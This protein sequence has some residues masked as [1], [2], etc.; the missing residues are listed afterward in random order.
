[1]PPANNSPALIS[2]LVEIGRAAEAAGHGRKEPIYAAAAA[3]LGLSRAT[4]LRK[5]KEVTVKPERKQRSDAG[6]TALP[7]EEAALIS[8]YILDHLRKNEKRMV[9]LAKAVEDLRRNGEIRAEFVDAEGVIRPLSCTA[10]A[11]ALRGHQMHPDQLLRP[12]P[13]KELRSLHPNHVWEIDASL[14]VLFY[15]RTS[16]TRE[17][18]LRVMPHAEFYKNKPANLARIENDR[19]WRYVATD[20]FSGAVQV[21]Y[22]LGAESGMN[23]TDSLIKFMQPKV[24]GRDPVHGAPLILLMDPG[25]ANT[26]GPVKNFARRMQIR[27]IAH[28]AGNARAT[29]QVE[30][31]QDLVECGFESG[32][33]LHPVQ[34]L[35]ELNAVASIWQR[36][37]N[38]TRLHTRTGQTRNAVWLTIKEAELRIPP[39]ADLCRELFTHEPE[40]RKVQDQLRVA[41]GGGGR[42]WDVSGVPRVMVGES[43][44]VTWNPY[45]PDEQV[46]I[47][48][49][50]E[51]GN[52]LLH[53]APLV[54]VLDD[55]GRF[56][57]DANV[58]GEEWTRHA[59]TVAD[60]HRKELELLATE[61][62]T[63][64]E[65][66]KFRKQRGALAFGGR[67]DPFKGLDEATAATHYL[68]RKG[69]ELETA[70]QLGKPIERLLTRFEAAKELAARGVA[71]SPERNALIAQWHPDGVPE[72]ALDDLQR[73][74]TVRNGLR[75]VGSD[76]NVG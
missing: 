21:N 19:V 43:L 60:K 67:I 6:K 18:G 25:S 36:H 54:R 61:T 28:K 10:I 70:T 66:A 35:D 40:T 34:S 68:P 63:Q 16:N 52:E 47:V 75:V 30:K 20:H 69:T 1:M 53:A 12:A 50:D 55:A 38:A 51:D 33:R 29:G 17:A 15:L 3:E 7:R 26:A 42:L 4:L 9:A 37:F 2:R 11:R 46:F 14:C 41:F 23:L 49:T 44:K 22:V 56:H 59:D 57:A 5:I 65:A 31:G 71:M 24:G 64:E 73:R 32:L 13:A 72:S 8:A 39:A 62:K 45:A 27:L 74:L 48:D 76:N 58:I